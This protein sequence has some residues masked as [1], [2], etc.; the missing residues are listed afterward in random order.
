[1]I[2][3]REDDSKVDRI[4]AYAMVH[5]VRMT[6][7]EDPPEPT[8]LGRRIQMMACLHHQDDRIDNKE[9]MKISTDNPAPEGQRERKAEN[10]LVDERSSVATQ[11]VKMR[12][13]MV[14]S[15]NF[16][17]VSAM[18]TKSVDKIVAEI[19][20][21]KRCKIAVRGRSRID[22]AQEREDA[23]HRNNASNKAVDDAVNK[24][25]VDIGPAVRRQRGERTFR[26]KPHHTRGGHRAGNEE[27]KEWV[28]VP[29]ERERQKENSRSKVDDATFYKCPFHQVRRRR[30][31]FRSR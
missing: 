5:F 1:M 8:D 18:V 26:L 11:K 9:L 24:E 30:S 27:R 2:P 14:N 3:N 17:K 13:L 22:P 31:I 28:H 19:G 23:D 4:P 21:N 20:Q 16:D 29:N 25:P 15:M 12:D 7:H 10:A 6:I